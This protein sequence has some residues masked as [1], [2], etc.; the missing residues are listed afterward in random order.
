[1]WVLKELLSFRFRFDLPPL[2]T[3]NLP[4]L[5]PL[6]PKQCF[7][8][9]SLRPYSH[10]TLPPQSVDIHL[11]P[12][13]APL[14][15]RLIRPLLPQ[16]VPSLPPRLRRLSSLPG[17]LRRKLAR[18]SKHHLHPSVPN[19]HHQAHACFGKRRACSC[20]CTIAFRHHRRPVNSSLTAAQYLSS[21]YTITHLYFSVSPSP[22]PPLPHHFSRTL[23]THPQPQ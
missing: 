23:S 7:K 14:L 13:V 16:S 12:S 15:L 9:S 22:L 10:A 18:Q 6:E 1:M 8:T 2:S 4:D 5:M 20:L 21:K 3:P 11:P 17:I 19:F